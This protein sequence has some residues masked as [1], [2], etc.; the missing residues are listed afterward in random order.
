[1]PAAVAGAA[2][3]VSRVDGGLTLGL[4]VRARFAIRLF[5][6]PDR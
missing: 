2:A 6:S 1:L 3:I 4:G 5:I